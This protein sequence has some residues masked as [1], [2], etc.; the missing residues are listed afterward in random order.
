MKTVLGGITAA[1]ICFATLW[2]KAAETDMSVTVD[3]ADT[4]IMGAPSI[5]TVTILNR[6]PVQSPFPGPMI[7]FASE[8]KQGVALAFKFESDS[9]PTIQVGYPAYGLPEVEF[10]RPP[11][12]ISLNI[13]EPVTYTFDLS[14]LLFGGE[15]R[16]GKNVPVG[17]YRV[18]AMFYS[19]AWKSIPKEITI[20]E[21]TPDEKRFLEAIQK[22]GIGKKWFPAVITDDN[23]QVPDD[24]PLSGETAQLR[25]FIKVLRLAVR[26][27][28][29]AV[30]QIEDR[31]DS[32]GYLQ[33][34]VTELK[35]DCIAKAK[36]KDSPVAQTMR[37]T[38]QV[39]AKTK[40]RLTRLEKAG[41]LLDHFE[42]IKATKPKDK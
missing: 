4:F 30:K 13:G 21:P 1:A 16:G 6:N 11:P 28:E 9:R 39:D 14:Q 34:T 20:R 32:W 24:I 42:E 8:L 23:L 40:G 29:A 2:V 3:C 22:Q 18:T 35:Y 19:G 37:N 10:G 15:L 25:D 5:M 41:G 38:L 12:G 31:K 17:K 27:P 33:D 26:N 36:G 7:D